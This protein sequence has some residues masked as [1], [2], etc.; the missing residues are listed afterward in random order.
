MTEVRGQ[1]NRQLPVWTKV[2]LEKRNPIVPDS[3]IGMGR[4]SPS[5]VPPPSAPPPP[6]PETWRGMR[7]AGGDRRSP[8]RVRNGQTNVRENI[9]VVSDEPVV[10]E[11]TRVVPLSVEAEEFSL[12]TVPSIRGPTG[13]GLDSSE[14]GVPYG[15]MNEGVFRRIDAVVSTTAVA[16][17]ASP[18][19]L[20]GAVTPADL[21]GTDVPAVV[22]MKLLAVAEVYSSAVENEG[23]PLVIRASEQRDAIVKV[24]PV[25]P[26]ECWGLVDGMTI[27]EPLEHSVGGVPIEVGNKWLCQTR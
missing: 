14:N 22:G 10:R 24:D 7:P 5:V 16:R 4:S 2:V 20:A 25:W 9:I 15:E 18:G 1:D 19:D 21:A 13:E 11:N 12:G 23:A 17:A 27:P 3:P 6:P 8:Q 26:G